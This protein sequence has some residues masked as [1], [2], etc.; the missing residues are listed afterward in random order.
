MLLQAFGKYE[1]IIYET[2]TANKTHDAIMAHLIEAPKSFVKVRLGCSE[3]ICRI[4][5]EAR[6]EKTYFEWSHLE[7]HDSI[8]FI[9]HHLRSFHADLYYDTTQMAPVEI[10]LAILKAIGYQ[11]KVDEA[12]SKIVF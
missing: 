6:D 9:G 8:T 10:A 7:L 4:R 12:V 2:T 5:C 1:D 11:P 3:E